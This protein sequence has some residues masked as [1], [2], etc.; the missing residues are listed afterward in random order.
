MFVPSVCLCVFSVF[1]LIRVLDVVGCVGFGN[2]FLTFSLDFMYF[3]QFFFF[4][5]VI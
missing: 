3:I 1:H 2:N 4:V 5:V